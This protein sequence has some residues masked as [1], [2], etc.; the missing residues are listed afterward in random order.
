MITWKNNTFYLE[1][2]RT[3][4]IMRVL[5]NG[6]LAHL[7]YGPK[8]PA[9]DLSW[10]WIAGGVPQSPTLRLEEGVCSMDTMPLEYPVYGTGDYRQPAL[11]V[12]NADGRR[13]N[14]LAYHSHQVLD[15]KP[16]MPG[17]PQLEGQVP[18]LE[19]TMLD[20]TDGYEVVLSYS[21]F[22]EE[23]VITRHTVIKN[24]GTRPIRIPAAAS[25]AMDLQ[26]GGFQLLSLAGAGTKE[27][28]I[29]RSDL[30]QGI[31]S[32]Q[33]RR[34][35]SGHQLNPFAALVRPETTETQGDVYAAALVYS[36]DFQ[37]TAETDQC[38]SVRFLAGLNPETF[39]WKLEP[40]ENFVTPEVLL[41]YSDRGLT[42][43]SQSYHRVC[44][45]YLGKSADPNVVH[46]IVINS[47]E[48]MYFDISE[49][50][51]KAFI[52]RCAGLGIDTFVLDDGWF[53]HR[54]N[55]QS[56]LG[57]WYVDPRKFPNGLSG[58]IET[59]HENGMKFGI[60]LEPEMISPDSELAK[61]HPDWHIHVPGREPVLS[62]NQ[63]VLDIAREDVREYVYRQIE[64]LL[65][66]NDISYI[67]W[68]M[69]RNITD[70][71]AAWLP[72]DRQGEHSHRYMLGLYAL[73][74]R[75]VSNFPHVLIEGCSAGGGRFDFGILYYCPQI[76][77]SDNSDAIARLKI[78]YGTSLV[79]PPAAMVGHVS[80]CPNCA[81]YR[82]TP[83]AAR[84]NVAQMCSF[85]YELDVGQLSQEEKEQILAQTQKHRKLDALICQGDFYRLSSPFASNI[86]AWQLVSADQSSSFV[87]VAYSELT[88]NRRGA[89]LKL[90]G[91]D[92]YR[93]YTVTPGGYTASGQA[94]MQAGIPA[95][96]PKEDYGSLTFDLTAE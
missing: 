94:L 15:T 49:E 7:Y 60:W 62:R 9:E 4:Y 39:Y 72:A 11:V 77:T 65:Q 89:R 61:T 82:T 5:S 54:D 30:H 86:C 90:R 96:P 24:T 6:T 17:L 43:M 78:Q 14:S 29:Q 56:S 28:H 38:G 85:G 63:W 33:S 8:L 37:I 32:L 76:W 79:Y 50:K 64:S 3:S 45:G 53:G 81:T 13:V 31:T 16:H 25:M 95:R 18:T 68:D 71:G 83:F 51:L 26:E 75:V 12:E 10:C 52:R 40:G 59:C 66:S 22:A 88:P 92:P 36:G 46:P 84:G 2:K 1:T 34:G 69:N 23:D 87:T 93:H 55:D 44:R 41:T 91:L 57:D 19:I 20:A 80:A 73:L 74:D 21:L 42:K 70:N 27:R 48:A 67:K 47:W 35:A 58:V